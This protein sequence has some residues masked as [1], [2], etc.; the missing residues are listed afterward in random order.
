MT[1]ER[2][3]WFIDHIGKVVY[4]TDTLCSCDSCEDVYNNGLLIKDG[5]QAQYLFD[6]E[7]ECGIR[8]FDTKQERE[9][10]ERQDNTKH[11]A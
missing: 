4:R 5:M 3:Q 6:V 10:H 8:Y 11:V 9:Q 1:E 7:A 2:K